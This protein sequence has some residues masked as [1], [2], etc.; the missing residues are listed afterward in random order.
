MNSSISGYNALGQIFVKN[1]CKKYN[2]WKKINEIGINE[3]KAY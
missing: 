2:L 3:S 1:I